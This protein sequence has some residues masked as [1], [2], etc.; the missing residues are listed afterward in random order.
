MGGAISSC[1]DSCQGTEK[2]SKGQPKYKLGPKGVEMTRQAAIDKQQERAERVTQLLEVLTTECEGIDAKIA[3]FTRLICDRHAELKKKGLNPIR[4]EQCKTE[5]KKVMQKIEQLKKDAATKRLLIEKSENALRSL[6]VVHKT[7]VTTEIITTLN[8]MTQE[9]DIGEQREDIEQL[10][11]TAQKTFEV[12]EQL[13]V[14]NTEIRDAIDGLPSQ[15]EDCLALGGETFYL[16]DD[17]QLMAAMGTF[18]DADA[19]ATI[20]RIEVLDVPSARFPE[21]PS[22]SLAASSL[23]NRPTA[24]GTGLASTSDNRIVSADTKKDRDPFATVLW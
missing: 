17:D 13:D 24:R 12:I 1:T 5:A 22:N 18:V 19:D 15:S 16:G 11:E 2:D 21:T 3:N 6:S 10:D 23:V 14:L 20:A 4:R 9:V 8:D 7:D